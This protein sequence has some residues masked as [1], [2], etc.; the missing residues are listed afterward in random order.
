MG[1]AFAE[2]VDFPA[3]ALVLRGPLFIFFFEIAIDVLE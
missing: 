3:F 1:V 2:G